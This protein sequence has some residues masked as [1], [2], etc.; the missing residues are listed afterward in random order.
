[1]RIAELSTPELRQGHAHSQSHSHSQSHQHLLSQIESSIKQTENLSPDQFP[2]DTISADLS[3]FSTQLSQLAPFPN[4]LKLLIWK[5]SYRL[6]N[7]CVDLSNAS[8]LRSLPP[9]KAED[10]AK[11]RHV[12]SDLLFIASDVSGVPSPAIKS[13]SFYLKTGLIWHDLRS[14]DL[15]SLCF[16]RATDIVSKIDIDKLSDAGE[17]KLLLDLN[18]ARSKTAWEIRDRNLAIALLNRAKGLLFGTPD[19]HK[20]LANQY[21]AFGKT[22]L[23]KSEESQD[24][25]DALK[26]MNEALDLY[27]KGLRE[28][29]TRQETVDLKDLRS[30]TL[31]FI[32][33]LHLQKNEFESVIKC[34]RVLREECESGDH[35]PSLSVLAMKAW[36]G[37]GKYGE[38]EKELR[39]M[40]VNKG[41]PEGVWVSAVEAYFQAAGTAGAE[42][43]KGVFLGLLGRCHVS[44]GSA[45]RV[46]H[47][48]IG[49]VSE[50][51]RVR[52]KVVAELVSDNR[53]VALFNGEGAAK[54]RTAMHAVLWNCGAEHF[55]SKDYETS[56]EMF[57]KA[58]LYIP[59]DI[60]SRILRAK[61]FRVL[62]LCHLGLS[63]LDQAH[64]YINEAEK[65]DP[66]IVSAFLKFKIYLQKKDQNGAIDQIQAM[67]TCLD[68]TPDFLSLAAHEAV[69][70]RALAVAVASLSNLL[71]FYAPGK[72]MPA[73]EVVVLRTL[74]TI[75]T[76]EPGNEL[77]AL[78]FVKRVHDRASELGSDC[79][80][81]TGEVGRRERNWF[82]V[83]SWNLGTKTGKEKNYEL[84][85]EFLRLASEFYGLLADGQAEENMV[86]K[87]LILSVSAIIASENQRKTTL[88]ESEVKQALELLD[89]AGKILKS[90]LPG[91]QL[92]GDQLTTT[93][94][95]LYFI[96]TICAYD[97]H[98]RLND[99]GSQLKL[100]QKF[101]SSKAHNPKHLLQIGISA[102]QG[103]R[104]NHEVATFALNECL[105][106]FLSSSSPDYQNVALIVRRLIGVTS[107]H[108]GDT[109]D[110]AVYGMY[111]QAYRVMVGL[112]DSEYPTEEGKWLAMTAWN[113][114]SLA[115]RL[116]QTDVARKWM[117]VGLQLAKHVPGMETYR[118]CMEDFIN[119]FEKRFCA[120]N[121][122]E[123]K[124][125]SARS[126]I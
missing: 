18:I 29:R 82:A 32:S 115:V 87:S 53:V 5:L 2:P 9:S 3:R 72:S 121:D 52:A 27:E 83:T 88:S 122:G 79:F 73:T 100:V 8:S 114:A 1:M 20:A 101:T 92:N 77:E 70:C 16:E 98:G 43:A 123:R 120:P 15:A 7:A 36:L 41:I 4:S 105:S 65:L 113:R 51:S 24:L 63:K 61:G 55:R 31:R 112:K 48:V 17:R 110:E 44:A 13:A 25:N 40:V 102:S 37:L 107:I 91:T 94:P 14:F 66:N 71:N 50:G 90:I 59:F 78:K 22:A 74:V 62:C 89:R 35:H 45:V 118:A 30:K 68:F 119:D 109:D 111:K 19:H 81:G 21:L 76:Q 67:A 108:K 60:E 58:M 56:A 23:A 54:Q 85:G 6:W 117:D 97:I 99:S 86:C 124:I 26:L 75:L 34:V 69:A 95:D 38:A 39:G 46:A 96:Y 104:T 116:G 57:E 64:E 93:E 103:P 28:A 125:D 12:A 84:C 10:H 47:R 126:I 11:L 80:F 33:A 42:T 106:A 49:D